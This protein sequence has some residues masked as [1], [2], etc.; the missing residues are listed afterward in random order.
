MFPECYSPQK[1]QTI[2][3]IS[4]FLEHCR[5]V[6][7]LTYSEP[8]GIFHV[9]CQLVGY[10]WPFIYQ[11]FAL[12]VSSQL[13][14][15]CQH[16]SN[17][18]LDQKGR[19]G[20]LLSTIH[21]HS[22]L[23]LYILIRA[24]KILSNARLNTLPEEDFGRNWMSVNNVT[25]WAEIQR[26][27]PWQCIQVYIITVMIN[28]WGTF[29]HVESLWWSYNHV[30]LICNANMHVRNEHMPGDEHSVALKKIF[31]TLILWKHC[32]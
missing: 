7:F 30:L 13:L 6:L 20:D 10:L 5:N 4:H 8:S 29:H 14:F 27:S 19:T 25:Y 12:M 26:G 23:I 28:C 18:N 24:N 2:I 21:L 3:I 9:L 31:S 11:A 22:T 15:T 17:I 1:E 16:I 32:I